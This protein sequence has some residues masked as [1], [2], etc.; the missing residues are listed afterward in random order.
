[1]YENEKSC[2]NG[3]SKQR[4][5]RSDVYWMFTY[6]PFC[7]A[8]I[9][10]PEPQVIIKKSGE[11]WVA[12]YDGV[13]YLCVLAP[14]MIKESYIEQNFKNDV[15]SESGTFWDRFDEIEITDEIA[16]LRPMVIV[17]NNNGNNDV[18]MLT[19]IDENY[20]QCVGVTYSR[21]IIDAEDSIR[22]CT[23]ND[24]EEVNEN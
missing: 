13:D 15:T 16:K 4:L 9:R 1:M 21:S 7:G 24:L 3:K 20:A 14:E 10:K 8:D 11:T 22:L 17:K 5:S 6:C 19:Y 12:L 23:V 2:E 18:K